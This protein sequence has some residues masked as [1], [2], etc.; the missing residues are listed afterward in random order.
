MGH[1]KSESECDSSVDAGPIPLQ[2]YCTSICTW[3]LDGTWLGQCQARYSAVHVQY[4]YRTIGTH[5]VQCGR[6]EAQMEVRP[7]RPSR[8]GHFPW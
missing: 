8:I 1:I 4:E 2:R 3:V 5:T 6:S 7:R